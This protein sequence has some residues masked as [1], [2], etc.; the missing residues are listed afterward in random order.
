MPCSQCATPGARWRG[1]STT[2]ATGSSAR[3]ELVAAAYR[4]WERFSSERIHPRAERDR[5]QQQQAPPVPP[6]RE[7]PARVGTATAARWRPILS[8]QASERLRSTG[9]L[10]DPRTT[11][12]RSWSAVS[13][14]SSTTSPARSLR[15]SRW[16]GSATPAT[17]GRCSRTPFTASPRTPPGRPNIGRR[18]R[19]TGRCWAGSRK[20]C[21]T[22]SRPHATTRSPRSR[23]MRS[24][25]S[26]FLKR[27]R[28]RSRSSRR[29]GAS[30]RRR[31]S[32]ALRCC[33]SRST[34]PI[35][36]D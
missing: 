32:P 29:S 20:S 6:G 16:N 7:R 8:P 9:P 35:A 17:N 1:R 12:T 18:R 5:V 13:A 15:R 14:S 10:L 25:A 28:S 2:G 23:T 31:R 3:Y 27:S 24:T 26:G 22:G 30:T 36:S 21:V 19:R 33:T 4:D 34:R 11:S